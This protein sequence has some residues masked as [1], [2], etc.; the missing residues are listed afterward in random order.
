MTIPE[1]HN[2]PTAMQLAL[3]SHGSAP[4]VASK[5]AVKC[6]H[7]GCGMFVYKTMAGD[8]RTL[9][10][11]HCRN[12]GSKFLTWQAHAEIVREIDGDG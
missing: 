9:R 2:R 12:C 11:E 1:P 6:P 5:G 3:Q 10:Y 4:P 8:T 7:C